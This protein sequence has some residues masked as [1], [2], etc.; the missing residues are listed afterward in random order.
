MAVL[1]P[2]WCFC[3]AVCA[4]GHGRIPESA[5][6]YACVRCPAG[7]ISTNW[8]TAGQQA[9][10]Q[11]GAAQEAHPLPL[12]VCSA[13]PPGSTTNAE[14]T[15]CGE[16]GHRSLAMDCRARM[17]LSVQCGCQK[18]ALNVFE[19]KFKHAGDMCN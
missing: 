10:V 18:G 5:A 3:H 12:N 8:G 4:P 19:C 16:W 6:P 1:P 17:T 14:Q 9:Q 11:S 7:H 2:V 13:C 15:A